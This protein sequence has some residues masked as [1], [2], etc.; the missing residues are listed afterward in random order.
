MSSPRPGS[1]EIARFCG[2]YQAGAHCP[3]GTDNTTTP[4]TTWTPRSGPRGIA[5]FRGWFPGEGEFYTVMIEPTSCHCERSETIHKTTPRPAGTPLAR[6]ELYFWPL[7]GKFSSCG[8]VPRSGEVVFF[9]N[10]TNSQAPPGASHHP[11]GQRGTS[12]RC[13][14]AVV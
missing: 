12:N 2:W 5:K 3:A 6:G 9:Y 11:S 7:R 1:R 14:Y 4:S 8:G 10:I 13:A